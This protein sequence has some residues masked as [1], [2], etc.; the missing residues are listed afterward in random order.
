M[1]ALEKQM[2]SSEPKISSL[3]S[4][5]IIESLQDPLCVKDS[6]GRYTYLNA[7]MC[8][9]LGVTSPKDAVGRTDLAFFPDDIVRQRRNDDLL[10]LTAQLPAISK[11][12]AL[13]E[14][15][16]GLLK[17]FQITKSPLKDSEQRII[18]TVE[19][20]RDI[21]ARKESMEVVHRIQAEL[22]QK[23]AALS[24]LINNTDDYIWAIDREYNLSV[25]NEAVRHFARTAL[26]IEIQI[27]MPFFS[28]VPPEN[29]EV[30]NRYANL[31][32]GGEHVV[33]ET[34]HRLADGSVR[35]EEATLNPIKDFQGEIFGAAVF[36][37]DITRRKRIE[38]ELQ[39]LNRELEKQLAE[40]QK[41]QAQLIQAE[42]MSSL[43]QMVA[44]IAHELNTPIGY[45]QNNLE[46]IGKRFETLSELY[47][48]AIEAIACINDNRLEDA[49]CKF[50]EIS[51]SE[52]ATK[53]SLSQLV[54]RTQKLFNGCMVG[55]EQMANLV[56]SMRNFSR[57]DEAE[58]KRANLLDGIRSS[59]L[60]LGHMLREKAIQVE[61]YLEPL[62][63]IDCYPAQLNQV[64]MNIIQ[65]AIHAVEA[66]PA[67][68]IRI[69][70]RQEGNFAVVKIQDNGTGI[71]KEIRGKIFDPFFTTKPV[72]KGTGLGL[73][74][75]YSIVEKHKGSISFETEEGVGTTFE[76][77]IPIVEFIPSNQDT[78][79]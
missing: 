64:F 14:P 39:V 19:L 20:Y 35:Y 66:S 60:M 57:L 48:K 62:P 3:L 11:E 28:I 10:L 6:G 53:E 71:P 30:W 18:G 12:E 79:E 33:F 51:E 41:T 46:L 72:G 29:V 25:A 43:G 23:E 58:M 17:W 34:S 9:L 2:L 24:S 26:G 13:I 5:L 7:A 61:T 75:A 42:K 50:Q 22:L 36:V 31:A 54:S 65:N 8:R 70:A 27:G 55:L 77:K 45:V 32:L 63:M 73:S 44:G 68:R 21:A 67:P 56:Q 69:Y 49:L 4:G 16:T 38:E 78:R 1:N 47:A 37:R 74:I 52:L 76:I 59:L 15:A 40:V